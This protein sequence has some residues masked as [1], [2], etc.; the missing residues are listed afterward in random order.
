MTRGTAGVLDATDRHWMGQA[1]A[2]AARAALVGEVPVGAVLVGDN[3]LLAGAHNR[4]VASH[5]PS[6]HAE[7]LVLREVARRIGN[8]RL[9][10]TTLYVTLEP[11]PM[12]AGA[13][14]HAR[15]TRVVYGASDPRGGAA[16]SVFQI[17]RAPSLN[18]QV[19]VVAG[20]LGE[21][22]ALLLRGFF[23]QRRRPALR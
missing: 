22:A 1:L 18:H 10:H 9:P 20:V 2:L 6:A 15:I 19:A 12:C 23:R 14:I 11:C 8:Y 3:G 7:I 21:E 13:I 5:D 4:P 16:G 17:L